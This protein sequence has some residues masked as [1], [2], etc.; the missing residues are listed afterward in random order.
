V[1]AGGERRRLTI[2]FADLVA[3]TDLVARMD[4]EEWRDVVTMYFRAVAAAIEG[5]GG[6][7][8]KYLGDGVMACFGHPRAYGDDAERAVRAALAVVD[9]VRALDRWLEATR[10]V[11]LSVRVGVHTGASVVGEG[12][13]GLVDV[14]GD[15]P[16]IASRVQSLAAPD[17]VL[18][19][20]DTNHLLTGLFV[21]DDQGEHALKGVPDPLRLYRVH[22]PSG[23]R[24]RLEAAM[25]RGLTPFVD[26][27]AEQHMLRERWERARSGEGRVVLRSW[28]S[29][30]SASHGSC[31]ASGRAWATSLTHGSK[32]IARPTSRVLRSHRSSTCSG[33]SSAAPTI[34]AIDSA[35]SE[36]RSTERGGATTSRWSPSY[37]AWRPAIVTRRC[38]WH[39]P[40]RAGDSSPP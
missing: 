33:S 38:S 18:I 36:T 20:A 1:P 30:A 32:G 27:E 26:R 10:G 25:A 19:S 7:V 35:G 3:S 24:G 5:A 16:H 17:S 40:R 4:P 28:A 21:T 11:R 13:G 9:E 22:A 2:V 23:A 37:S 34:R 6:H 8:V 15:A 29:Q 14:F 31:T 12:G 39:R